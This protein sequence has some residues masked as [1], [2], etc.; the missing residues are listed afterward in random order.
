MQFSVW[1]N[2]AADFPATPAP[3]TLGPPPTSK[4]IHTHTHSGTCNRVLPHKRTNTRKTKASDW[5]ALNGV[6]VVV[7]AIAV[8]S[9]ISASLSL[10][11]KVEQKS[12]TRGADPAARLRVSVIRLSSSN[13]LSNNKA[14]HVAMSR[15]PK[16]E[17]ELQQQHLLPQSHCWPTLFPWRLR[18]DSLGV[19]L[20]PESG[21][22]RY[23]AANCLLLVLCRFFV[24]LLLA[25]D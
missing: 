15:Q 23:D 7:V 5:R 4:Y 11:A 13:W 20:C 18:P 22:F 3:T 17:Q 10:S 8:V 14:D 1:G 16:Q 25:V 21:E 2:R 9:L 12:Q 19:E 6:V 24:A